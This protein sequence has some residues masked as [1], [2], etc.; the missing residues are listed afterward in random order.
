MSVFIKKIFI[1]ILSIL[2]LCCSV[3]A[4]VVSDNDGSAFITKAEFDNMLETYN[5]NIDAYN[6]GLNAKI[7]SA[8]KKIFKHY[9]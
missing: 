2:L 3:F 7:D 5:K 4:S 6:S 1:C 9:P 8:T